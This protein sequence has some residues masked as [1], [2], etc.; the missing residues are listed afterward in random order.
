MQ[1]ATAVEG[2][3]TPGKPASNGQPIIRTEENGP[4]FSFNSDSSGPSSLPP[5]VYRSELEVHEGPSGVLLTTTVKD[6]GGNKVVEIKDNHW[7]VYPR[8]SS[9]KNYTSN[10][11]EVEDSSGEVV[12]QVTLIGSTPYVQAIWRDKFGA[13]SELVSDENGQQST[14]TSWANPVDERKN[15][16]LISPNFLYPSSQHWGEKVPK[17]TVDDFDSSQYINVVNKSG[18]PLVVLKVTAETAPQTS[19]YSR[20]LNLEIGPHE[21][22]RIKLP[23]YLSTPLSPT[24]GSYK[25]QWEAAKDTYKDCAGMMYFGAANQHAFSIVQWYRNTYPSVPN[26]Y[27]EGVGELTYRSKGSQTGLTTHFTILAFITRINGCQP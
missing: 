13:G 16:R 27:G 6:Q 8:Y 18:E 10:S 3:L 25:E 1:R 9:D 20:D 14:A 22:K 23:E 26:F 15:E 4:S 17:M 21:T 24:L 11:L 2:V 5:G 19:S 12:L 7:T